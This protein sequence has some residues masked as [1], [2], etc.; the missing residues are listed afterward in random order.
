[1]REV[2]FK[3]LYIPEAKKRDVF[4]QETVSMN[5]F[6]SK[7]TKRS[8]YFIKNITHIDN[9]VDFQ[10][11]VATK[12]FNLDDKKRFH[13]L[14]KHSDRERI[15]KVFCKA[16]GTF[17]IVVGKDIYNIVYIHYLKMEVEPAH[18]QKAG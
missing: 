7:T 3:N 16:K 2:I 12:K 10:K 5:G 15:D 18:E 1:M 9:K 17:Y 11:W 6:L 4:V 14:K 13:I 8:T